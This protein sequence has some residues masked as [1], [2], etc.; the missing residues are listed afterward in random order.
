MLKK[1]LQITFR[2]KELDHWHIPLFWNSDSS[3]AAPIRR[4]LS[5]INKLVRNTY[6]DA[7]RISISSCI[8]AQVSRWL[9]STRRIRSPVTKSC[10]RSWLIEFIFQIRAGLIQRQSFS[11]DSRGSEKNFDRAASSIDRDHSKDSENPGILDV[12]AFW[13]F[14]IL[15]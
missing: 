1:T 5:T 6:P 3:A 4:V 2:D 9:H 13:L 15:I 7:Q 10:I 8:E 12:L 14:L 11:R